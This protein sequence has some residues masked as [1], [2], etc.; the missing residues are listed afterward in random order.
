MALPSLVVRT[1]RRHSGRRC[2]EESPE[3]PWRVLIVS[4][5]MGAGHDGAARELAAKLRATGHRATVRDLL[6]AAPARIGAGLRLAYRLELRHAPQAY[7]AVY[8]MW[9]HV[10]WLRPAVSRLVCALAGRRLLAWVETERPDV[11]I[12]TYPLATLALGELRR[13]GRL[14]VPTINFITDFGVH[15]LWVHPGM[16]L[17]LTVH[18]APAATARRL[19]GRPV[20]ACGPVVSAAFA[21][22]DGCRG[23]RRSGGASEGL[24]RNRWRNEFGIG[25][26]DLAILVVAGSWGVGD[27]DDTFESLLSAGGLVPVV[28]CGRDSALRIRLED[29]GERWGAKCI[30][31]GWTDEMPALMAACDVLVENAGGLTS[32]E[33]MRAGLP[34]VSYR[35]IAGH[36]KENTAAMAAAGVSVLA[37]DRH[38]L[39][40]ALRSVGRPG[41]T[42]DAQVKAA[43]AI[44]AGDAETIVTSVAAWGAAGPQ[45]DLLSYLPATYL[46]MS[47]GED[48]SLPMTLPITRGEDASHRP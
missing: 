48:A 14:E 27:V 9:Y 6:E 12:S 24:A 22:G 5:S 43:G 28:V 7:D 16:D 15:P 46:P 30:V 10:A 29:L 17:N 11:V 45:A 40:Q 4:A 25:Q 2:V 42:R 44:F 33:A 31:L 36:G 41:P 35:P 23:V 20:L 13:S 26:D 39:A 3:H 37:S 38:A 18:E 1:R 32:L 8:R 19:S 47:E 34:V 21:N